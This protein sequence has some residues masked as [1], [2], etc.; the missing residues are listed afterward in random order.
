[1][2]KLHLII[3]FAAAGFLFYTGCKDSVTGF[4]IDERDKDIPE[5]NVSFRTHIQPVLEFKCNNSG[6]HNDESRAGS[7]SLTSYAN[8]TSDLSVVFPGEP[9]NSLLVQSIQPGAAFPMPPLGYPPLTPKQI[10]AITTW[11][12]EGAPN[13]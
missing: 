2:S 8:V 7:L 9:Q 4:Q 6:C 12:D 5:T 11:I 13:N 3:F 1:M 10:Q